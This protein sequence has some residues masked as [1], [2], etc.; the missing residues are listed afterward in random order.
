MNLGESGAIAIG[1]VFLGAWLLAGAQ[2]ANARAD[3]LHLSPVGVSESSVL[4]VGFKN[5]LLSLEARQRPWTEVLNEIREKT[6]MRLHCSIPLEGSVTVSF[7]ALPVKQALERL[8]GSGADFMFRY[9]EG[10]LRPLAV[11]QE[12]WVIGTVRNG[13]S[14]IVQAKGGGDRA[15]LGA[16]AGPPA[17]GPDPAIQGSNSTGKPAVAE[18]APGGLDLNDVQVIDDLLKRVRD[19]DPATRVQAILDLSESGKGDED[20]V[21]SALDAALTDQDARVRASAVHTL[22]SRGGPEAMGYLWQALKDPDPDVRIMAVDSA[23]PT[24]EGLT[25]LREALSDADET[26]RSLAATRLRESTQADAE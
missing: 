12:V 9:P 17:V 3:A 26:V 18:D 15:A 5:G 19:E 25:L 13:G 2:A 20:T 10:G 1:T 8:F 23:V 14:E 16:E 11:P 4:K 21:R 24:D 7:T 6:G 22:A